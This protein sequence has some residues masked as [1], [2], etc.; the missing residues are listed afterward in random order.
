MKKIIVLLL[1]PFLGFTQND[2]IKDIKSK[3]SVIGLDR[4]NVVYRGVPNPIS[5]A[6]NNAKSYKITGVGVS[7]NEEGKYI[8]LPGPGTETKVFVEIERLNGS[9]VV[10]E[11]SFRIK[12]LPKGLGT[13][14]GENCE[15]CIIEMSKKELLSAEISAIIPDFL[16]DYKPTVS[17]FNVKFFD[18]TPSIIV[19]G[20]TFNEEV[21]NRIMKSK[22]G[23][24]FLISNIKKNYNCHNCNEFA[25][26]IKILI[27]E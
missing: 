8:L 25:K 6:V 3:L 20:N 13:I 17:Q 18:K 21:K 23:T 16:F 27:S 15:H 11:H 14:N 4:M 2:T 10:E 22:K 1:L 12:G 24:Y 26:P 5:I 19:S 9:K 7:Q